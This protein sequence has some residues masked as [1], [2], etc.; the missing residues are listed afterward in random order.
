MSKPEA[1]SPIA[2]Q[3]RLQKA[4]AMVATI[5]RNFVKQHPTVDPFDQAGR[6]WLASA[7]WSDAV[8]L[9]I[10]QSAGYKSK[11]T[12]GETTR[13]LVRE[14]YEGRDKAPVQRQVAS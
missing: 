8:W 10:A 7:S 14:V 4:I 6:I 11:K 1:E 5:D 2:T 13:K 12:P 9:Q 3:N